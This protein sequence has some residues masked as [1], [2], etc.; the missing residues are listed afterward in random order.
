MKTRMKLTSL[1]TIAYL[2]TMATMT[3]FEALAQ[4]SLGYWTASESVLEMRAP[5]APQRSFIAFDVLKKIVIRSLKSQDQAR[6]LLKLH[7][8]HGTQTSASAKGVLT[9]FKDQSA[10][11]KLS[12]AAQAKIT[13]NLA[14]FIQKETKGDFLPDSLRQGIRFN[15]G[16]QSHSKSPFINGRADLKYGLILKDIEPSK[17]AFKLA[18]LD[19]NLDYQL[20]AYAPKAN[21]NYDIGPVFSDSDQRLYNVYVDTPTIAE[22][23]YFDVLP[24]MPSLKFRG[25]LAPSG[26]PTAGSPLPPQLLT[27]EQYDGYY[28]IE[29]RMEKGLKPQSVLHKFRLPL[30]SK[31]VLREELN[32]DLT[33]S[34]M[35]IENLYQAGPF[36]VQADRFVLEKRYQLGLGWHQPRRLIEAV[37]HVPESALEGD[38]LWRQHRWEMK[39]EVSF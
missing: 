33:L 20:V 26:L 23:S 2:A 11:V 37:A 7:S 14:L 1:H 32:K 36:A 35:T 27:L 34:R 16:E 12:S 18:A 8:T 39:V 6:E 25:K 4:T 29:A 3:P 13:K 10:Q 24:K 30:W 38:N 21:V 28:T 9:P 17:T 15:A 22:T 5:E 31:T 19:S